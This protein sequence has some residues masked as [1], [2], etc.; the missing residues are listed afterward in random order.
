MFITKV[1]SFKTCLWKFI[2]RNF[3]FS[4]IVFS[5]EWNT[6]WIKH[7]QFKWICCK[8][9]H[10]VSRKSLFHFQWTNS[11][12]KSVLFWLLNCC[13]IFYILYFINVN[14]CLY[15]TYNV[16]ILFIESN[17]PFANVWI[18]LS[19]NDNKL[20][21]VKSLNESFRMHEISFAFNNSNC[22]E[23]NPRNT[24]VGKFFIL[25]PYSTLKINV[26]KGKKKSYFPLFNIHQ[27]F[28]VFGLRH[29]STI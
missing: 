5:F 25:L 28:F 14:V 9:A 19:Y 21:L 3:H 1:N 29:Q 7:F 22:N 15:F 12:I 27:S 2:L 4:Y 10:F 26:E 23:D 24:F 6:F 11:S 18:L 16:C 13:S 20:K 8:Y 17:V